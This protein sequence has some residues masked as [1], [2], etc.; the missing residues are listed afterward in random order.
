M[1]KDVLY[2]SLR[3]YFRE[4]LDKY[5]I[6]D[7]TVRVGAGL[8]D[9]DFPKELGPEV[10]IIAEYEGATG[11][12]STSFPDRFQG[13]LAEVLEF[14]IENDPRKRSVFIAVLN[15][16]MN[17]WELSDD[18]VSCADTDKQRCAERIA[19]HYKRSNGNVKVMVGGYQPHIVKTLA[20]NFKIRVLD[21]DPEHIGKTYDGVTIEDGTEAFSDAVWWA[22]VILCTGSA[23]TNGT[24]VDYMNMPKDI[25]FYGTT[26][27]GSARILQ[28]RRQC[29]CS[30]N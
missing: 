24:I 23:I 12:C 2:A 7:K 19:A 20:E 1:T 11:E 26:I 25:M 21:L 4:T 16:V 14:D 30:G 28:L 18:C 3:Q 29:P 15:A 17:K 10:K 13:T 5:G 8:R 27:A 22:D 9:E 6:Y